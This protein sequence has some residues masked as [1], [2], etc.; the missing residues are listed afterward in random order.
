MLDFVNLADFKDLLELSKEESLLDA[1]GKGP[2]AEEAFEKSNGKGAVLSQE[3]H[4]AAKELLIELRA[5]LHLV[6][7]DYHVFEEH[8]VLV[9]KWYRKTTNDACKDVK[10]LCCTVELMCL[11]DQCVEGLIDCLSYHLSSGN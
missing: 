7:W 4:W 3:Q 1:V 11:V 9:T 5:G 2:I 8:N 10:Q 6:Q